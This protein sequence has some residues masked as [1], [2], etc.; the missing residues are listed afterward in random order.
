MGIFPTDNEIMDILN[1]VDG[2]GITTTVYIFIFKHT[3]SK[4]MIDTYMIDS[5]Q[6]NLSL[7]YA[8][9]IEFIIRMLLPCYDL[10]RAKSD[11]KSSSASPV[12]LIHFQIG[13]STTL[14]YKRYF[15][16]NKKMSQ[17][18]NECPQRNW[19]SIRHIRGKLAVI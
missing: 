7:Q 15:N 19:S 14:F 12:H 6:N 10:Q 1:E 4:L 2:E 13:C 9:N 16:T 17:S 5:C 3:L 11:H 8:S 18:R